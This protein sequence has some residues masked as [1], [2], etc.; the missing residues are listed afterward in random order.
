MADVMFTAMRNVFNIKFY[1]L[2]FIK[3]YKMQKS[4]IALLKMIDNN[5]V[6]IT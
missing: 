3:L 5:T 1:Y 4:V 2:Y 6:L